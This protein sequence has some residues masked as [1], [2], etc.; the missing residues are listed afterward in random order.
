[1]GDIYGKEGVAAERTRV[2]KDMDAPPSR[3]R[4][5]LFDCFRHGVDHPFLW[6]SLLCP[7][8]KFLWQTRC[9]SAQPDNLLVALAQIM[10]RV[11]LTSTGDRLVTLK[12]RTHMSSYVFVMILLALANFCYFGYFLIAEP[13]SDAILI[14]TLPIAGLDLG[15]LI[16]FLYMVTTT[17]RL[18]RREFDIPELRCHGYEDCCISTFCTPCAIAQMGRHTADYETYAAYCC[19]DT[20]LANH[21]EVKL[22]YEYMEERDVMMGEQV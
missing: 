10:G 13:E 11:Q 9:Q 5:E 20:G 7:F 14:A 3:W 16:Y 21:I 18:V 19:T 2:Y 22:P 1:M 15:V 6:N 4:D 12:S 8:G 17:R